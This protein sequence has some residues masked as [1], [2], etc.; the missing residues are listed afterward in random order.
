MRPGARRRDGL[1]RHPRAVQRDVQ[2]L[3]PAPAVPRVQPRARARHAREASTTSSRATTP[4]GSHKLNSALAQAYY[5]AGAG[6]H[7]HHHRDRAPG[8]GAPRLPRRPTHYGLDLDV[9]M[10]KC[11]YEQKPFRRNIMETFG[12]TVTPSPQRHDRGRPQDARRAPR[13]HP[14]RSAPPSPR[15][16]SAPSTCPRTSGRY[17]L[18]SVLN[19]VVLHQSVIGLESYEA[20]RELGEYPDIVIGCAGGG[21][22]LG[23]LIAPFMR[24]KLRGE[25]APTRASSPSSPR[26]APRS[27]AAA[28]PTT[29]PTRARP[30]RSARCTRSA[31]ASSRAP[32]TR[33]ASATTA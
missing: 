27:R 8:S 4:R 13:L 3:P 14:D 11:S 2:G 9:F 10:V 17:Q 26:A 31:T 33:A 18:G 19:Q 6:P 30:A 15:P 1:L 25:Q 12:A 24:D 21:S 16:W 29:S 7:Q 28:T 20:L 23:G 22:N 32:T 5:A